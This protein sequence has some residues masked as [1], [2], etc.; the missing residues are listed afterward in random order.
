MNKILRNSIVAAIVLGTVGTSS[1]YNYTYAK[2]EDAV[3][4]GNGAKANGKL[5]V[6]IGGLAKAQNEDSIAIG[7]CALAQNEYAMALGYN[8]IAK[9]EKSIAAGV[10]SETK[11]RFSVALGNATA[12]N[13]YGS[14]ALGFASHALGDHSEAFGENAAAFSKSSVAIGYGSKANDEYEFSVGKDVTNGWYEG[15]PEEAIYRRITHV[16]DGVKDHD[17]VTVEQLNSKLG[18]KL[19]LNLDNLTTAGTSKVK[20]LAGEQITATVTQDFVTEKVK[21]GTLTSDTLN[22][23]GTGKLVG[24]DLKI[25]LKD[26]SV[27][28]GKLSNDLQTEIKGKANASDLSAYAK[29]DATNIKGESL[30]KWQSVLGNGTITEKNKGL[31]TGGKVYEAL[32]GK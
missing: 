31:V 1:F 7:Y 16:A 23:K 15:Y 13:G 6:A 2:G 27:T 5:S 14:M 29:T 10:N 30:T 24:S 12:A 21:K 9:G 8:S 17:A 25:D 22:V 3:E 32:K 19:N 20:T 4:E 18:N 28:K 26:G 11:G